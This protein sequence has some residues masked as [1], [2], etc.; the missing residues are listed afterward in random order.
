MILLI[1]LMDM[2]N[3]L[4]IGSGI[5]VFVEKG[6]FVNDKTRFSALAELKQNQRKSLIFPM[7][8]KAQPLCLQTRF[9]TTG[10]ELSQSLRPVDEI[11]I[12]A[13]F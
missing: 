2:V 3:F 9:S 11:E 12:S 13:V 8:E 7:A 5:A 10:N 1:L 6:C 4:I